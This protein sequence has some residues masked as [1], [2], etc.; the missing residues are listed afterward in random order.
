[1][2]G[3]KLLDAI[4]ANEVYPA[5]GCTEPIACAFAAAVATEHLANPVERL[6]LRVD[7]GTFKNGAAVTVPNSGGMR[8]NLAAAAIGAVLAR[9]GAKLELLRD[10]T[11]ETAARARGMIDNGSTSYSCLDDSRDFRVEVTVSGNGN[12]VRCVLSEGHAN[13]ELVEKNGETVFVRSDT[14]KQEDAAG[15]RERLRAMTL[16]AVVD[17]VARLNERQ[18]TA[19]RR[20]IEMN[21]VMAERGYEVLGAASQLKRMRDKGILAEDLFYR[22]KSRV[23]GAVDARMAGIAQPVMTSGGSGNQGIV[24]IL[25]PYLVGRD[26]DVPVD[27]ILESLAVAHALNAYIKCFVGELSVLCGCAMAA[28][29]AAAVAIVYQE[30]GPDMEKIGFAVNNVIGD[31][32]GLICDG[33]KPG[34]AMKTVSSVDAAMR[35]AFMALSG[36]GPS[37]DEGMVGATPEESIHNLGRITLEGMFPVDPTLVDIMAEKA[38]RGQA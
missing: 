27:R 31:L 24:A 9:S 2:C 28:G 10:A 38:K 33:A 14:G 6:D 5:V 8:G 26:R 37:H 30:A 12:S 19:L 22:V 20:G 34:C 11:A 7:T 35:A 1:M 25:T 4:M 18:R 29:I 17:E 16:A 13:V 3:M 21:V 23:A 15:Y 32:S 36:F